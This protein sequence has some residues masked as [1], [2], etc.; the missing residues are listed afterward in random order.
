MKKTWRRRGATSDRLREM[1]GKEV[2]E[3]CGERVK[4][5]RRLCDERWRDGRDMMDGRKKKG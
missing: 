1:R 5:R 4:E 3:G 2:K